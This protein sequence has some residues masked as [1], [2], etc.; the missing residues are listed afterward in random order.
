MVITAKKLNDLGKK[1]KPFVVGIIAGLLVGII[2]TIVAFTYNPPD[3]EPNHEVDAHI[4]FG[5]IAQISELATAS[6]TYTVVEKVE[7]TN[8]KIFDLID[9]PFTDNF[10]ILSYK[11]T[12]KAGVNLD[13][14]KVTAEAEKVIV[15]LPA[16]TILSD[17]IDTSSFAVL[18]EQAGV[19]SPIHVE[20]VTQ[21]IDETRQEAEAA[22]V[23]GKMLEEARANAE[24]SICALLEPSLPE[25]WAI[26]F[27]DLPPEE[28][29]D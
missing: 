5:E 9:I 4:L 21:Y 10:F 13:E 16:A 11:G 3:R 27:V 17:A 19:F 23:G 28:G 18:H 15:G 24:S 25:G 1:A 6:E 29:T 20:D 7:K 22:S 8:D 12:I 26:E 2:G 14:A